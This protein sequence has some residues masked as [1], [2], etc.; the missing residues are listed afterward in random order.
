MNFS[1]TFDDKK[2]RIVELNLD[3]LLADGFEDALVGVAIQFDSFQ[4]L[5]DKRLCLKILMERDGMTESEAEKFFVFSVIGAWMGPHTP[6]F[7]T[8]FE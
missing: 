5:Y 8:F 2:E 7:A 4:A 1:M 6:I 3:V